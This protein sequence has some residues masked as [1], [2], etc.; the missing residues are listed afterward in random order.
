MTSTRSTTKL[1][2]A[3]LLGL[4]LFALISLAPALGGLPGVGV[5]AAQEVDDE[6][7]PVMPK[8]AAQ[9]RRSDKSL[10]K[11]ENQ[12]DDNKYVKAA[13]RLRVARL[14]MWKARVNAGRLLVE[15]VD[16]EEG[17]EPP[18]GVEEPEEPEEPPYTPVDTAQAVL[19]L[20]D[21]G[22]LAASNLFDEVTDAT[23]NTQ[24]A[25]T[26]SA[27][28]NG[29]DALLAQVNALD[30]EGAG[31]DFADILPDLADPLNGEIDNITVTIQYDTL[32]NQARTALNSARTKIQATLAG[33]PDQE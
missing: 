2:R 12:I 5:A 15:P 25:M 13:N 33:L 26:L 32:A 14:Y 27:S 23:I 1:P 30:P 31:A 18:E 24:L 9:I 3:V 10:N 17:A 29:R 21:R 8:V 20:Q 11:A 28:V 6:V 4:L 16:E 22:V 7:P 19:D